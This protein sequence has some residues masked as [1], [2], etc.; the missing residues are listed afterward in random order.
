MDFE[1]LKVNIL[2]VAALTINLMPVE[3]IVAI[4]VGVTALTYNVLKIIKW[5][6]DSKK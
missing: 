2:N 6:Q 5:F 4:A 3:R 1:Y